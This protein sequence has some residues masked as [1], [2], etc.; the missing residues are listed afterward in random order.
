MLAYNFK[1][2]KLTYPKVPEY[3]IELES[4]NGFAIFKAVHINI[5]A[6]NHPVTQ[7]CHIFENRCSSDPVA[8]LKKCIDWYFLR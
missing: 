4:Y 3:V 2:S 8:D 7:T 6:V 1:K 5:Y